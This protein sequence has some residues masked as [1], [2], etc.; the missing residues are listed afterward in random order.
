MQKSFHEFGSTFLEFVRI[1]VDNSS[2]YSAP[3]EIVGKKEFSVIT[4]PLQDS[5]KD[6][7]VIKRLS[8]MFSSIAVFIA[9]KSQ[10]H[11]IEG[12]PIILESELPEINS[13]H[14]LRKIIEEKTA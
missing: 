1:G 12:I 2:V 10:E 11:S 8:Q 4:R 14:E 7:Q 5:E 6:V 9:K 13:S 3:F